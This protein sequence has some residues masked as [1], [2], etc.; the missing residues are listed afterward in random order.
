MHVERSYSMAKLPI[1]HKHVTVPGTH[2]PDTNVLKHRGQKM[3]E[4]GKKQTDTADSINMPFS[5][6]GRTSR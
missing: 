1:N 2:A 3:G 4:V 5:A 6:L